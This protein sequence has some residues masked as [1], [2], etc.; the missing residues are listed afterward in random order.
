MPLVY[1]NFDSIDK[2]LLVSGLDFVK[3]Q[4]RY[5]SAA[6]SASDSHPQPVTFRNFFCG[7]DLGDFPRSCLCNSD[8]LSNHA[9][10]LRKKCLM[11]G[12]LKW[13]KIFGSSQTLEEHLPCGKMI[14]VQAGKQ[15]ICVVRTQRDEFYAIEDQCPHNDAYLSMGYLNAFD[16]V[17]CPWHSYCY[18]LK[19][20][21]EQKNRTRK[22]RLF[23]VE[24]R[25]NGELW[26]QA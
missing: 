11:F 5:G 6:A 18:S 20:G 8:R 10:K 21:D 12:L 22:A 15:R 2:I 14:A 7:Y 26:I 9:V 24:R 3:A 17:I 19:T 23:R 4:N 25:D 1:K 13:Y 16:E